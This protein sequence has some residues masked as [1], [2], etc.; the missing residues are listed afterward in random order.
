VIEAPAPPGASRV[1]LG[2]PNPLRTSR[3][4]ATLGISP[5]SGDPQSPD[6]ARGASAE[7]VFALVPRWSFVNT[8]THWAWVGARIAWDV[9]AESD[10]EATRKSS[11]AFRDV[12]LDIAYSRTLAR[13][14][15]GLVLL[16]GPRIG[17]AL[18]AS[19][20]SRASS[21]YLRTSVGL[22]ADLHVPLARGNWFPGLFVSAS[23]AWEYA[24]GASPPAGLDVSFLAAADAP[25][26]GLASM[27]QNRF[28]AGA[29]IPNGG[30]LTAM[31][32]TWLTI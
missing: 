16:A 2:L 7:G 12:E 25:P 23:G 21:V 28:F 20:R 15:D 22:G 3:F 19:P 26:L 17:V 13:T 10:D 30:R 4:D 1:G 31:L 18:P 6:G 29:A 32:G 11:V 9:T 24:F 14:A 27:D 8:A 5:P